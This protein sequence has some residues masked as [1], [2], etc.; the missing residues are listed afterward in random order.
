[1][2]FKKGKYAVAECN[3]KCTH[4]ET[5]DVLEGKSQKDDADRVFYI[6]GYIESFLFFYFQDL[7]QF[8]QLQ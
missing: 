2:G 3:E 8:L 6:L 4:V 7:K 5:V 1:V